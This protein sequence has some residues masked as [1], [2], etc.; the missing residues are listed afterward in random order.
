MRRRPWC[1]NAVERRLMRDE[2]REARDQLQQVRE[3]LAELE[4]KEAF[5]H[6]LSRRESMYQVDPDTKKIQCATAAEAVEVLDLLS[7]KSTPA[8]AKAKPK[9]KRRKSHTNAKARQAARAAQ[10]KAGAIDRRTKAY[11]ASLAAK[12]KA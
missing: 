5:S 7:K 12:Q 4:Q 11:R 6:P 10:T 2:L 1:R 3:A 9:R 8:K